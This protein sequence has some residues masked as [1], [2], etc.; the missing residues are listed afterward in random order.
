MA[1]LR[2]GIN[3]CFAKIMTKQ[4]QTKKPALA[5]PTNVIN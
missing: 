2:F 1:P 5:T 4:E 3:F